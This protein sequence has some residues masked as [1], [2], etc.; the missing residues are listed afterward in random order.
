LELEED[1]GVTDEK[2]ALQHGPEDAGIP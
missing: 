1:V 2:R